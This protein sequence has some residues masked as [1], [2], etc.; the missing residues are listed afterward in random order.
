MQIKLPK[1]A[2]PRPFF[3]N[4]RGAAALEFAFALPVFLLVLVGIVEFSMVM[5]V[6]VL[7]EGGLREAGRYGITG[8]IPAGMTREERLVEIVGDHTHGLID[9]SPENITFKVYDDFSHIGEAEP[10]VDDSPANG[11]YDPGEDFTDW[12]DNGTWDEDV[13]VAGTGGAEDIVVYELNY[14]W[15]FLTPLFKAF[16]DDGKINMTA[17]LAIRNEPYAPV[18]GGGGGE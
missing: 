17:S 16:G 11:Q 14:S 3:K 8:Q 4:E 1:L 15:E 5:L 7:T 10:Y 18:G 6:S 2:R 9:L 13:G 12:N